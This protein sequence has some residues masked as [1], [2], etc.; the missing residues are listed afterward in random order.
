MTFNFFFILHRL[1]VST[2]IDRPIWLETLTFIFS[3][4]VLEE[5]I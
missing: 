4:I 3:T 5:S 2:A 1:I